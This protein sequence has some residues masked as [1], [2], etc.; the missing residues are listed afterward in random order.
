MAAEVGDQLEPTDAPPP[1]EGNESEPLEDRG[2]HPDLNPTQQLIFDD[3]SDNI[4]GHAEKGSGK[5]IA[6]GHKLVRHAYETFNGL[7]LI[8]TPSL[9][10]GNEGIWYDLDNLILPQW[11][12]GMD[13][14]FTPSKLD[15]LTK[16]RHRWVLNRFGGWSKLLLM[17]IPHASMVEGR[18]K[19]PA[20][21]MV[22]VDELTNCDG[23]EYYY[24]TSAQLGRR[25]NV[26]GAPQQFTASCNPDGP[27][28]WVYKVFFEDCV[29]EETG[30]QD[31]AYAVYHVPISENI[32]RLPPGYVERLNKIFKSDEILASRLL[33]GKWVDRPTGDGLFAD[34]FIPQLHVKG[35][36]KRGVGLRPV[37]GFPIILGYDLG[38]TFS[39]ISFTQA[40]PTEKKTIWI[41]F[42]EICRLGE[43]ALY[44]N[45]AWDVVDRLQYWSR[46][47][48]RRFRVMHITDESAIN[49]WRPGG[50]G[51]YD[52]WDFEKV[53]NKVSE[54]PIKMVGCPKGP[55]SVAAR[56]RL[57]QDKLSDEE[58]AVSALCKRHVSMLNLLERDNKDPNKPKRSQWI[59]IFDS[60]TYP[61]F[62]L[63]VKGSGGNIPCPKLIC[64][65]VG[66]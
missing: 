1:P 18:V 13:L 65:G 33:D 60:L 61:M 28:H 14:E 17:S 58:L 32:K 11:K 62:R 35:D 16:D 2:W 38:Q 4:L 66:G 21:S 31:P 64:A 10:T 42:D 20:P 5:S 47:T 39:S 63:E 40:I 45:L 37:P 25:R 36:L 24:F 30:E 46:L 55:G 8:I 15:P 41:I 3:P 22:Y 29:D 6:F 26:G 54:K 44:K 9:R 43:K 7:V 59:H 53:Y 56:I 48:A 51:S 34:L 19:G 52:A 50:T 27:S 57:L 23:P 12:E 49:Q